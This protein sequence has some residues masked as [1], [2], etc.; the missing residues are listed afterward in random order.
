MMDELM[1]QNIFDIIE[2]MLPNGWNKVV[3]YANYSEGSYSIKFYVKNADNQYKDCYSLEGVS[4]AGLIKVFMS[5]DK[6]ISPERKKLTNKEKWSVMTLVV[7]RKGTFK[8]EYEYENI[9]DNLFEYESAW[10]TKYLV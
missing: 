7:N 8:A 4:K 3:L 10:K 5:I 9:S 1:Y 6:I 2:S